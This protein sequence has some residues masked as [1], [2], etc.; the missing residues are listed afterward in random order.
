MVRFLAIALISLVVAAPAA[1]GP[2]ELSFAGTVR[3]SPTD[4]IL[5][6]DP[7]TSTLRPY[8]GSNPPSYPAA[9]GD[10]LTVTFSGMIPD[11]ASLP[12]SA[13]GLY[14]F[15]VASPAER[16][17]AGSAPVFLVDTI[18]VGG[19]GRAAGGEGEPFFLGGFDLVYDSRTGALALDLGEGSYSFDR[20]DM[21]TF[22]YDPLADLFTPDR[23]CGTSE[24][25]RN[26][27][28]GTAA[29]LSFGGLSIFSPDGT[30]AGSLG[31]LV[32]DGAFNVP[33]LAPVDVAEPA[34]WALLALGL[35]SIGI[36]RRP[37]RIAFGPL[38]ASP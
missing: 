8:A 19:L 9:A 27:A 29:T 12:P 10:P 24:C 14:R 6:L 38:R 13:D 22:T 20:I 5:L 17:P 23:T 31:P 26:V 11:I 4:T 36:A 2:I 32:L 25:N 3:S 37:G 30:F 1:A 15:P 34:P 18:D 33:V 35:L 28:V 21:P 7:S 16:E